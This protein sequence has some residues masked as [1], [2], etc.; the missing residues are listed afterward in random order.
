MND[1]VLF[2]RLNR[3]ST[4]YT[5]TFKISRF[6]YFK[7]LVEIFKNKDFQF[8]ELI[9]SR[10]ISRFFI[11]IFIPIFKI[12][13]CRGNVFRSMKA[14]IEIL[15]ESKLLIMQITKKLSK[16]KYN[17]FLFFFRVLIINKLFYFFKLTKLVL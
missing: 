17:K 16:K 3:F 6:N 12:F 7:K 14:S 15:K 5:D 11:D 10:F 2:W 13:Y 4:S 1:E 8:I 9:L